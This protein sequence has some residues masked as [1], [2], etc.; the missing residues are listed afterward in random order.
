[1]DISHHVSG[2]KRAANFFGKKFRS[3]VYGDAYERCALE[4]AVKKSADS[5]SA[6]NVQIKLP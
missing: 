3:V 6:W 1:M 5:R 2:V 4:F